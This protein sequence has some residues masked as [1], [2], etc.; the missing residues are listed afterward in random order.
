MKNIEGVALTEADAVAVGRQAH[1]AVSC[2][3]CGAWPGQRCRDKR[4]RSVSDRNTHA[5]RIATFIRWS[6]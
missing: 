2:T 5:R 1:A 3:K 4:G 6:S